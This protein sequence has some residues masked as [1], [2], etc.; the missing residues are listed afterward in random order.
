[1]KKGSTNNFNQHLE[2]IPI[3]PYYSVLMVSPVRATRHQHERYASNPRVRGLME[4]NAP[5]LKFS[6]NNPGNLFSGSER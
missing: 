5:K 6:Y 3:D 4:A 1:M 2:P